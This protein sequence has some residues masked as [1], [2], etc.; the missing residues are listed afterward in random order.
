MSHDPD[1]QIIK[2][3]LTDPSWSLTAK[4]GHRENIYIVCPTLKV[5]SAYD[6]DIIPYLEATSTK[7]HYFDKHKQ[8][9]HTNLEQSLA[10]IYDDIVEKNQGKKE[11]KLKMEDYLIIC[12]DC[13]LEIDLSSS[14]SQLARMLTKMRHFKISMIISTQYLKSVHPIARS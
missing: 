4:F 13:L 9:F 14:H 10:T 12:D 11:G 7:E 6:D 5:D 1:S 2:E 3:L 8:T